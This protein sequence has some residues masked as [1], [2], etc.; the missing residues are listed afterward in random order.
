M[1]RREGG[2]DAGFYSLPRVS[3]AQ[4]PDARNPRTHAADPDG[5]AS[6]CDGATEEMTIWPHEPE[7][8]QRVGGCQEGPTKQGETD[9]AQRVPWS[10]ATG[11]WGPPVSG[12]EA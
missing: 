8:A 11:E 7:E 9:E 2:L 4:E 6:C 3:L 12:R 1:S 10:R 5:H